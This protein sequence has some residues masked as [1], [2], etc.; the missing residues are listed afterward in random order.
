MKA[1]PRKGALAA[2]WTAR[3][4]TYGGLGR[5]W[6]WEKQKVTAAQQEGQG[7]PTPGAAGPGAPVASGPGSL[8]FLCTRPC[9]QQ[10]SQRAGWQGHRADLSWLWHCLMLKAGEEPGPQT[11]HCP[12][13]WM[14]PGPW[15]RVNTAG[16][17]Q[18]DGNP[19]GTLTHI[20]PPTDP[21]PGPGC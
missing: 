11:L 7:P 12:V 1:T 15:T 14:E 9:Q 21:G 19:V 3:T 13:P 2:V 10:G 5:G 4:R 6:Q 17:G 16:R 8:H 20:P 18:Q